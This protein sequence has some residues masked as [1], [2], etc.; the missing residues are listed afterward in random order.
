[1]GS[2]RWESCIPSPVFDSSSSSSRVILGEVKAGI[3]GLSLLLPNN[4]EGV[5]DSDVVIREVG[6]WVRVLLMDTAESAEKTEVIIIEGEF[7]LGN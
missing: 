2:S 6:P 3:A 1:M 5:E 7:R 4:T